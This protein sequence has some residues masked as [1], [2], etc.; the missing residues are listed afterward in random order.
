MKFTIKNL[1]S[2]CDL[3]ICSHLLKKFLMENFIFCAVFAL[4]FTRY[5]NTIFFTFKANM[6]SNPE[7]TCEFVIELWHSS[8]SRPCSKREFEKHMIQ[9]IQE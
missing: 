9:G 7:G 6:K 8:I 1:L 4:S 2:K 3:R 5:E